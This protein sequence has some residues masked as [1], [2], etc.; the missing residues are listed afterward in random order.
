MITF[1][2]AGSKH[3]QAYQVRVWTKKRQAERLELHV[4]GV[5]MAQ[6]VQAPTCR[7]RGSNGR[8]A[9]YGDRVMQTPT[10]RRRGSHGRGVINGDRK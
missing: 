8:R 7:G 6:Q 4:Q 10:R 5:G 3:P 1:L 9:V 2:I